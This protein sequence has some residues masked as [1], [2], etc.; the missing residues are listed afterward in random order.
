M[1]QEAFIWQTN[2]VKIIP[3]R[4]VISPA[5]QASSNRI[6]E[7]NNRVRAARAI[8]GSNSKTRESNRPGNSLVKARS[9]NLARNAKVPAQWG[10]VGAA[11]QHLEGD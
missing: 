11:D 3:I 9:S 10:E 5:T 7:S 8:R 2:Q 1:T 6:R 4:R